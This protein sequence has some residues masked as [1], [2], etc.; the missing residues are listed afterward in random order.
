MTE[1]VAITT[2]NDIVSPLYDAL[3]FLLILRSDGGRKAVDVRQKL[4]LGKA[5]T[6]SK[7]GMTVLFFGEISNVGHAISTA[8]KLQ[9][10]IV[11][12]GG[13]S[14]FSKA[15]NESYYS[16][17]RLWLIHGNVKPGL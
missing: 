4:L 17:L 5:E 8:T 11:T 9:T 7:E 12:I 13:T 16:R 6:Y 1:T 10:S 3:C 15:G 14:G 2:W